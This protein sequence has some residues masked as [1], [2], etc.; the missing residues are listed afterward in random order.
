MAKERSPNYPFIGLGTALQGVRQL[1][2]K[3][4]RSQVTS[5][6]VA[7][8]MGHG[9]LSGPATSKVA[10]VRQYGLLDQVSPGKYRISD[11]AMTLLLKKAGDPEYDRDVR[12]AAVAPQLFA[13]LFEAYPEASDDTLRYHLVKEREF[14]AE[15]A[16]RVIKS[17]RETIT[18]AKL[19]VPSYIKMDNQGET[20][21]S[22]G[23]G[24]STSAR[25][26]GPRA[27]ASVPAVGGD[28]VAYSWPLGGGTHVQLIFSAEPTQ[29]NI[30][31]LLAQLE[32]V[33]QIAPDAPPHPPPFPETMP[34]GE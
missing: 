8:A 31:V 20:G 9:T 7:Q 21:A 3:E 17:F 34:P 2:D 12:K 23:D 30:A 16:S 1:Y 26:E 33:R 28:T 22:Q 5:L 19:G 4:R 18:V 25:A 27:K 24:Q 13:E 14:S 10:A 6:A 32:I 29:K 11:V 15:G